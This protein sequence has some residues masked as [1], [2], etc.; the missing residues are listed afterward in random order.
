MLTAISKPDHA[1][2]GDT[3]RN[4]TNSMTV[5]SRALV[6]LTDFRSPASVSTRIFEIQLLPVGSTRT[7][8][9][10]IFH[11]GPFTRLASA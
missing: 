10:A 7:S 1:T 2:D 9:V 11:R 3:V 8:N 6:T 5:R 4:L